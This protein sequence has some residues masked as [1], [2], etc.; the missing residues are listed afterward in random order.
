[1]IIFMMIY[2]RLIMK[3]KI[4]GFFQGKLEWGQEL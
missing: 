2:Q 3:N 1:M 4:I